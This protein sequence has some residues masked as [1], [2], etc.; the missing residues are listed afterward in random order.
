MAKQAQKAHSS[1]QKFTGIV[2]IIDEVV[3]LEG[4]QACMVIE[5]TASNFALLSKA[6]QDT[7]LY[8]YAALLNSLTFPIQIL[9]RNKRIDITQYLKELE[10][11]EK[12]AQNKL[13]QNHIQQYREFIR[14]MVK[15]NVVLNKEFYVVISY[16]SLEQGS[17][18]VKQAVSQPANDLQ[19]FAANAK[20]TLLGKAEGLLAQLRKLATSAD[21][22]PKEELVKLFY[23]VYNEGTLD[24]TQ[25]EADTSTPVVRSAQ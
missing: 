11:L 18:G 13:L 3:I 10:E 16:S 19:T 21:I 9:I 25:V 23:D 6:E 12:Q 22:L 5:V 14:E 24:A 7:K 15:V 8:S 2:D 1:T 17:T 4:S 20:K